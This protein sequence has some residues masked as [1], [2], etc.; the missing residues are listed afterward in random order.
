[1]GGEA[2]TVRKGQP[3]R[4]EAARHRCAPRHHRGERSR[5]ERDNNNKLCKLMATR[6]LISGHRLR[7]IQ[8]DARS[9]RAGLA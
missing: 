3:G 2:V 8:K 6:G 5:S 9:R 7:V 1:M 4:A